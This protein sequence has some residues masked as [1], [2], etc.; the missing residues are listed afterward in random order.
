[1]ISSLPDIHFDAETRYFYISL[2]PFFHFRR[3]LDIK[4]QWFHYFPLPRAFFVKKHGI[5]II[6]YPSLCIWM[7]KKPMYILRF[8]PSHRRAVEPE[9][10]AWHSSPTVQR[11]QLKFR[12]QRNRSKICRYTFAKR[13]CYIIGKNQ[14]PTHVQA[15]VSH[16][17]CHFYWGQAPVAVLL[18]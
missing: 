5:S 15:A 13:C 9:Q 16:R 1:M 7:Q 10:T 18:T 8:S 11:R 6:F 2:P 12:E 3:H 4:T 17:L 14:V